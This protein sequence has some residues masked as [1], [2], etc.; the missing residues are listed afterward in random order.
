MAQTMDGSELRRIRRPE[1]ERERERERRGA[2]EPGCVE[3]DERAAVLPDVLLEVGIRQGHDLVSGG[4]GG[5]RGGEEDE[6]GQSLA[7]DLRGRHV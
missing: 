4:R 3:L 6:E 7:G 5:H 2:S 1:R